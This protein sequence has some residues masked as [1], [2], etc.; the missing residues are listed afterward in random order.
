[1]NRKKFTLSL[2]MLFAVMLIPIQSFAAGWSYNLGQLS[3]WG[4]SGCTTSYP[5]MKLLVDGSHSNA[6][7][8]L[9]KLSGSSWQ[10]ISIVNLTSSGY[11]FYFTPSSSSTQYRVF[12]N[13][14]VLGF[15]QGTV[16]CKG[17]Y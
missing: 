3:H 9:Q 12:I 10:T 14:N 17:S 4:S 13:T 1:M 5:K 7:A 15:A 11:D 16:T 8:A 6:T 2:L